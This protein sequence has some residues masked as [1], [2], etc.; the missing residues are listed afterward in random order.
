MNKNKINWRSRGKLKQ[1]KLT[2]S[3]NNKKKYL[4]K[5]FGNACVYCG[6]IFKETKM[7]RPTV[8]HLMPKSRGGTDDLENLVISCEP[9]NKE[10]KDQLPL[11]YLHSINK[12]KRSRYDK[13]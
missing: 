8:D 12:L 3:I 6:Y 2:N 5:R 1:Q 4:I 7:R 9:C 11:F 13:R 10:K